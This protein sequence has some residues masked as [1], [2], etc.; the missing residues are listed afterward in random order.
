VIFL[1]GGDIIT[2]NQGEDYT[3]PGFYALDNREDS[4]SITNKI[5]VSGK[6]DT[7]YAGTYQI[8]Y[9]VEDSSGNK[10]QKVRYVEVVPAPQSRKSEL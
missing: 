3:D 9:R 1:V 6:V 8:V 7:Q 10:S 2:I 4:T 5:E